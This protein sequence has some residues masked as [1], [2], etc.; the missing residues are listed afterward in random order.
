MR[1]PD[2]QRRSFRLRAWII[3]LVVILIILLFSLRGL[4]VIV[5]MVGCWL[6]W[7]VRSARIQREAVAMIRYYA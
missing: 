4:A 1:V 5:L 3:A 7:I 6:G 2:Q